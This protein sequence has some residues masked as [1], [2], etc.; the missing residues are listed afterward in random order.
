MVRLVSE[1]D[2][3]MTNLDEEPRRDAIRDVLLNEVKKQIGVRE[4]MLAETEAATTLVL[5]DPYA[6]LIASCLDRRAKAER[7]W[8]IPH[9]LQ[10]KLGTLD[11]VD[12]ASRTLNNLDAIIRSLPRKPTLV[13]DAPRTILDLSRMIRDR[14]GARAENMWEDRSPA[15]FERDLRSIHGVGPG[16]ASMT[17]NLLVRRYGD[18]FSENDL[19]TV[20]IKPDTHTRRV[21]HRLGVAA[22]DSHTAAVEAA[23]RL[24]P[25]FP[26]AIDGPLWWIGRQW[27]HASIPDC[28]ACPL[29]HRCEHAHESSR[30]IR[31]RNPEDPSPTLAG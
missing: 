22:N 23:R 13:N 26:G 14:F 27:C 16:I 17:T 12:I 7:I 10:Q 11:V 21:L 30:P 4:L 3:K 8:T 25:S 31:G 18:V 2:N 9:D 1:E 5:E 19:H 20:D 29:A 28:R 15:E 24:N 6:F